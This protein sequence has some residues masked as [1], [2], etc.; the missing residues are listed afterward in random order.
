M[1]VCGGG[2]GGSH[3]V[4]YFSS[5]FLSVFIFMTSQMVAQIWAELYKHLLLSVWNSLKV[6][7]ANIRG[8]IDLGSHSP[9]TAK[10][11]WLSIHEAALIS[12]ATTIIMTAF[13]MHHLKKESFCRDIFCLLRYTEICDVLC[14]YGFRLVYPRFLPAPWLIILPECWHGAR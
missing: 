9:F 2:G 6:S 10:W 8:R 14:A 13:I 12:R 11:I 4:P 1:C 7:L 5:K 3:K